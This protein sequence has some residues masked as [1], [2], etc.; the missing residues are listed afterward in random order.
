MKRSDLIRVIQ[1]RHGALS[2]KE[3]ESILNALL[4]GIEESLAHGEDVHIQNLGTFAS[5]MRRAWEGLNPATGTPRRFSS[6]KIAT[7]KPSS[8]LMNLLNKGHD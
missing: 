7:F 3:A 6:R 5:T 8:N 1:E 2:R 4:K